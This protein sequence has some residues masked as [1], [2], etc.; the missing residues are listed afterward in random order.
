MSRNQIIFKYLVTDHVEMELS[1]EIRQT[2]IS[3][4]AT[5]NITP[6]TSMS[7]IK[8]LKVPGNPVSVHS[9]DNK[10]YLGHNHSC[11]LLRYDLGLS[12]RVA[13]LK[14]NSYVTSMQAYNNE[15]YV[16]FAQEDLINVYDM[17]GKLKRS[18]EHSCLSKYFNKL[19]VVSDK[20]VVSSAQD[21]ALTVYGLQGQLVKQIKCPAISKSDGY[22]AM[23]VCGDGSVVVSDCG[24]NSLF[25]VNIDSGEVMWT[26][27]HVA[28][29]QGVVC[30]ENRHVL[31]TSCNT[32]TRIWILDANT[33]LCLFSNHNQLIS[34]TCI[35]L[36]D[37]SISFVL[38]CPGCF[39]WGDC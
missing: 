25:R 6:P 4:S 10:I 20:V 31:V 16:W 18:W 36:D 19:R 34:Y 23:A 13:L 9:Y 8:S 17:T 35:L 2:E 24:S 3:L 38:C 5:D 15:L 39:V 26:S 11:D 7:L 29:S 28:R 22:K 27:K 21:Q 1:V 30:F 14:G 33:G 37:F 12:D 32:D